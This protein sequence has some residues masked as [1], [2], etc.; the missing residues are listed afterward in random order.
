MIR[1][2]AW[3]RAVRAP[4]EGCRNVRSWQRLQQPQ[5]EGQLHVV[6]PV[7]EAELVVDSLLVGIH[8]LGTDRELFTDLR[9]GVTLR[10]ELHHGALPIGEPVDHQALLCLS[11]EI[12]H[13]T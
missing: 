1:A 10:D 12:V 2:P 5:L 7:G 4:C 8:R 13:S 6:G 9:R 3:K 11:L